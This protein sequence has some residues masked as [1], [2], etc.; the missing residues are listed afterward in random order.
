MTPAWW[1]GDR[2]IVTTHSPLVIASSTTAAG[3]IT[4]TSGTPGEADSNLTVEGGV[5][6]ESTGSFVSLTAG[7]DL[8]VAGTTLQGAAERRD[9]ERHKLGHADCRRQF[10][11]R[12]GNSVIS[13]ATTMTIQG[14]SSSSVGVNI[15]VDG[16]ITASSLLILG[17]PNNDTVSMPGVPANVPTTT[18]EAGSGDDTVNIGGQAN[19]G[20][21]GNTLNIDGG[22]GNNTVN[23]DYAGSGGS[24]INVTDTAATPTLVGFCS[25]GTGMGQELCRAYPR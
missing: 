10:H 18:I 20:A 16:T 5:T 8:I 11:L 7:E 23:V 17:G 2:W 12:R 15:Q 4:Y 9:Q 1:P 21:V 19:T 13:A 3:N 14:D 6:L 25:Q 24:I 22:A